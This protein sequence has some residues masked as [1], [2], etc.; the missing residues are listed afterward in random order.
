MDRLHGRTF[1]QAVG[2]SD[3]SVPETPGHKARDYSR[4]RPHQPP[5]PHSLAIRLSPVFSAAEIA[6]TGGALTAVYCDWIS[7][8]PLHL[9]ASLCSRP[10]TAL[11]R[12][13]GGSDFCMAAIAGHAVPCRSLRFMCRA[14]TT[15]L[16]PTIPQPLSAAF[17]RYPL[18]LIALPALAA[19]HW[20]SLISQKARPAAKPNRVHLGGL[21]T[22]RVTDRSF[23]SCSSPPHLAVTQ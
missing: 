20:T 9:P 6:P 12:S 19:G 21:V 13:Y 3:R 10:V 18:A 8:P 14:F 7:L 16:S 22:T 2:G 4:Y 5:E 17:A 15:V 23:T 1:S 11:H